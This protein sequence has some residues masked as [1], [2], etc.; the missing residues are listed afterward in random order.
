MAERPIKNK[1]AT[2]KMQTS[3]QQK[4][5]DSRNQNQIATTGTVNTGQGNTATTPKNGA[6]V[7][8]AAGTNA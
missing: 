8:G 4:N 5:P 6:V 2:D 7:A 3:Q 1:E